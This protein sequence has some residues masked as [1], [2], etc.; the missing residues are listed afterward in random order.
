MLSPSG[1]LDPRGTPKDAMMPFIG[2]PLD[3][4][5]WS[6]HR[7]LDI[8]D[9]L[10]AKHGGRYLYADQRAWAFVWVPDE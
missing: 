5:S 3:G 9:D 7:A 1:F 6:I 8:S 4:E 2:G 10:R